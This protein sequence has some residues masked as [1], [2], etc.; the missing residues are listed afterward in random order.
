[1]ITSSNK[2]WKSA[3][4]RVLVGFFAT[5]VPNPDRNIRSVVCSRIL[6]SGARGVARN[7]IWEGGINFN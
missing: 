6:Q 7:F 1:M 5:G 3:N 4:D 2:K